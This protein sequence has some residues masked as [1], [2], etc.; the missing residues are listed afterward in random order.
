MKHTYEALKDCSDWTAACCVVQFRD[1][2]DDTL[3][4]HAHNAAEYLWCTVG[5]AAKTTLT[6]RDFEG[7]MKSAK[8]A[9]F[10]FGLFDVDLDGFVVES[11]LHE[12][13][14]AI[15]RCCCWRVCLSMWTCC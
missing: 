10:V 13:F 15:Y 3:D 11:E 6:Q 9:E 12:R 8:D 14:E 7:V 5:H 1:M 4:N 2:T